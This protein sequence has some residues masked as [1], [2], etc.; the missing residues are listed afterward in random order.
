MHDLGWPDVRATS[1]GGLDR[2]DPNTQAGAHTL[3]MYTCNAK[4]PMDPKSNVPLTD[5]GLGELFDYFTDELKP[6]L[7]AEG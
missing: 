7:E 3:A 4:Y 5:E 6:C 2:Q 1:D